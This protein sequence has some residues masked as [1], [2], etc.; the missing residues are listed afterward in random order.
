MVQYDP[1]SQTGHIDQKIF[2]VIG[3]STKAKDYDCI[4]I[5]SKVAHRGDV[6][7][8]FNIKDYN[9]SIFN[10]SPFRLSKSSNVMVTPDS[11]IVIGDSLNI[12]FNGKISAGLTDFYGK[13]FDFS[14]DKFTVSIPDADSMALSL[15]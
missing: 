6:N 7:A 1:E 4:D 12:K 2:D 3:C 10:V 11:A 14:Y 15:E 9:L 13:K 5:Y 8:V